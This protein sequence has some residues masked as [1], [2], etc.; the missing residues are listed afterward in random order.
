MNNRISITHFNNQQNDQL[1]ALDFYKQEL[2]ILQERLTEVAHKNNKAELQ[3]Q[4][5]QYEN[6]LKVQLNNVNELVHSIHENMAAVGREAQL[7]NAG[8]ITESLLATHDELG[9]RYQQQEQIVNELRHNFN[10]FAAS[11]M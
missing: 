7:P 10:R 3:P 4:I 11:W 5:E 1:R 8:Y 2:N 6:Q 9:A